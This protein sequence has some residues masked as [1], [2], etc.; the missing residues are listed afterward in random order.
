MKN[1]KINKKSQLGESMIWIYRFIIIIIIIGG[2]IFVV[3]KHYSSQYDTRSTEASLMSGK[4]ARFLG[5]DPTKFKANE[6]Q[7]FINVTEDIFVNLTLNG[8]NITLGNGDLGILCEAK[9]NKVRGKH[10][11]YCFD[12]NYIIL[13]NG[14]EERLEISIAI[15]KSKENV[16]L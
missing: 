1:I 6:I 12:D 16:N 8:R 9:K 15:S 3:V 11:P 14:R 10:L 13:N 4:I 2:F 5:E 7:S